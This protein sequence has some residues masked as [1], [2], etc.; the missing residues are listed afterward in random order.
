MIQIVKKY[1]EENYPRPDL[2]I[3]DI[4]EQVYLST[5][6]LSSLFKTKTGMTVG[7][8]ITKCR[9]EKAKELLLDPRYKFYDIAERVGYNDEN[10]FARIFRKSTGKTPSAY[11]EAPEK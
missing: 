2:K 10:Y 11:K 6:Y 4:A 7:Q 3:S 9:V 8:Y 5:T 1:I